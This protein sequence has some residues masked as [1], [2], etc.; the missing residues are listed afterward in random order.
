MG[1]QLYV[2]GGLTADGISDE[3]FALDL[4]TME[5]SPPMKRRASSTWPPPRALL[6]HSLVS[7]SPPWIVLASGISPTNAQEDTYAFNTITGEWETI[8]TNQ[9][10]QTDVG[11]SSLVYNDRT[12]HL[13]IFGGYRTDERKVLYS[14]G[15]LDLNDLHGGVGDG[16]AWSPVSSPGEGPGPLAFHAAH[17]YGHC[18]ILDG[19]FSADELN[20]NLWALSMDSSWVRGTWRLVRA[21]NRP[22]PHFASGFALLEDHAYYYGGRI[23][24]AHHGEELYGGLWTLSLS[25][26]AASCSV[27]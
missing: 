26:I 3:L 2:Y 9:L 18:M 6:Q 21:D 4:S 25:H 19:G 23:H 11:G 27:K 14:L 13:V 17:A 5:W 12:D 1:G 22:P 7:A 20:G 24:P 15:W 8:G 10:I 16:A